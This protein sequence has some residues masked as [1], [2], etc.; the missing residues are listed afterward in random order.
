[1]GPRKHPDVGLSMHNLAFL[2]YDKGELIEAESLLREALNIN[3]K[4]YSDSHPYTASFLANLA[5]VLVARG[6]LKEAEK[7]FQKAVEIDPEVLSFEIGGP[8]S[9]EKKSS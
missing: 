8:W 4:A 5:M 1:V 7:F 2:L 3:I 6:S 9:N